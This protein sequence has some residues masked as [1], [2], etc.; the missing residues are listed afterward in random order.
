MTKTGA[1]TLSLTGSNTYSGGT[2][3]NGGIL[4]ANNDVDLGTG[5]LSFNGGTLEAL[6]TGSGI[7][8]SK[9]IAINAGGGTFLADTG[10]ASSLSGVISGAG[11]FTKTGGGTLGLLGTNT[12]AGGTTIAA[13][14]L[15][16]GNGGTSGSIVGNVIDNG[17]LAFNRSDPVTFPGI[18]S[19]TGSL[20][21]NGTGTLTLTGTSTY[22]GATAVSAGTLQVNGVLGTTAVT[23][24]SGAVLAGQGTIGGSVT[25]QDG[26]HLALGSTAQTLGVG[27]LLLNPASILD[28]RL[29]TP[30]VIGSGVNTL[31]NVTGNL[32][33]DGILNVTN[34]GNFASG[35]YRLINYSGA[36]TD[37]TLG[38]GT[39]PTGFS[40]SNVTVTTGVAGQVNLVVNGA[41]APTQFWDGSN[42]VFDHIVHGGTGTWDNFTTNFTDAGVTVNQSWQNGTAVFSATPGTVTLGDNI[43][44]Q[45]M[46]FT[47]AGYTVAGAGAFALQPTGTATIS[48]DS[49]VTATIGAPIVGP[50]GLNKVGLGVL[51]LTGVNT[52]SGGTTISQGILSVGGDTNLGNVSGGL[53]LNGGELLGGNGFSSARLVGINSNGGTLAVVAGGAASLSGNFTGPGNLTIGDTVNTGMVS[54]SG[55]NSYFGST[56]V[57][58]GATLQALSASALSN[59]SAFVVNGRL[60]LAGFSSQI[61]S[62]AGSGTVTSTVSAAIVLTAGGNN[63]STLFS[64]V[65][66]DGNGSLDLTKT[67]TGTLTLTGANSYNGGT[68]ISGGV[69]QIGSGPASGSIVGDVTDNGNLAFNRSDKII[70]PGIVSGAGSLSQLGTGTLALTAADN[71]TGGTT[72]SAGTLQIGNGGTIGSIVGNV[73]DNGNLA[74][75]R[76]DMIIF[77]GIVSGAGS[78][79]QVGTGTLTL[80]AADNYTGG[81]TISAGTLQIGNGGIVGSIVGN[82]TD[83]GILAF[84]HTDNITFPGI[85]SGTGTLSQIGTGTLTLTANNIYNGGTIVSGTGTL[86]VDKDAE[87][88]NPT[89]G[90]TLQGGELL[91]TGAGFTTARGVVV[92]TAGASEILAAATGTT[93]TYTGVVSGAGALVVGEGAHTGSIVLTGNNSY[94]GGTTINGVTLQIGNG[95]TSGSIAGSVA[96]N[97]NLAF[98][99]SDTVTFSGIVSGTGTLNQ[100]GLGT[101]ILTGSSTYTGP[102]AVAVGTLQVDGVLGNTAVTVQGGA[103][104]AGQ[105]T[106]GGSV[107]IQNGAHLAPGPGAQ[108]LNV[109][110]L[111]LNP[112]SILDY[113]LS[114][115]GVIG[116]GVNSLVNVGGNLT[117]DGVL[118]VTN[119][120]GFGSGAYR[121]IN[122]TGTLSDLTLGLGTLPA[123]FTS[124]NVTVT[125]GVVGQ[126]NLVVSAAGA[127]T[128][129]W[130]GSN[131]VSDGTVHGGAGIW[132]NFTTNFTNAA[133]TANQS[134]QNGVAVF[135]AAP[136]IV[137]LGDNILFQGMQFTAGGYTI[138]GAGAFALQ[139]TGTATITTDPGVTATIAAP[140]AGPG[141][142]NKAGL[143]VLTLSGANTYS[144]GTTISQG[145]LSVASDTNLGNAGV[146]L[147]LNGGELLG[148]NGFSSA[149]AVGVTGN[150]GTLSAVTGGAASFSGNAT[151]LGNLTIGDTVNTG[152][153]S[154]SGT[155]TYTGS[156]TIVSGA[157]L[158]ALSTGAFS[159]TSAFVVNGQLDLAGF[160]SQIGSLAG[161]GTVTNTGSVGTV[162]TAGVNNSSTIFNGVV[163]DGA[164]TLGL[165]K[166]GTGTLTLT[167]ADSYGGGTT[168]SA[169]T[170]QIGNAGTTGSIVGNVLDNGNLA[171]NRTDNVTFPGIV[172][173]TGSLNQLG[174]GTLTLTAADTYAGITTISA[175]TLQIG[176]GGPTGSIV[177][178]VTDNSNLVFSRNNALTYAGAVSGT[179]TL[180]QIGT[181]TLALTGTNTYTGVTTISA[182]TLQIGNGGT[183]GSIVGNV[184][185]NG[186][187]AY[188]RTDIVIF[189]GVVSGTGSLSQVGTGT[190]TLTGADTYAGGTTIS[191]GTLQIGNAGTS[192]SIVGNVTDNG[193]LAFNR[194]DI[195]VFPGV[196]SGTGS[197]SQAGTGTVTLTAADTYAGGTTISAGTLQIGNAGTSGSL[198]GNVL[199]N[200]NLAFNHTDN[201][202]FPGIVAGTGTLKQIGTGTLTLTAADTYTGSTTISA[203]ILQIG[204]GG[205][206][207]SIV[208]N[209]TDNSNLSFN[210]TDVVTYAGVVSG[211]GTLNQIGTGTL[212]L[213]GANIYTGVTTISAGT[214]QIGNGGTIGSIVGNVTDNSNLVFSRS[215]A[216]TYAGVV[217]GA[218]TLSQSGTGTLTLTGANSYTGG[219][220]ING[221]TLQ[222]GNAGII[223]SIVGDVTDNGDLAFKRTDSVIFPGI[224]SG[225]G[226]LS[227]IGAG[228]LTLTVTDTYSGGT[229]IS[230]GTLQIGNAGTTGSIVGNVTD[231]GNLAFNRTD[232]VTF[233]GIVSGTGTLKQIGTGTLTLTGANIYTGVTTISAGTLQIGNGATTGSIVGD[234]TDNS[235]LVFSRNNALTY[236]G[237]VSGAGTLS[238][239]GTGTL[240]LTGANIYTGVTTISA[241]TLQIGNGATT[242]SIVGDVTDN[243]NL[244]FSRNNALTYAG[245]VSGAGTLS[246][247]GTGTLTLTGANIYTG[248]TT[249]SAG[250]LQIGNGATT[251]SIVGDVTD[252]SNLVFSRNNALTYAGIVSGAGTLSQIGTG[253][254][255]LTGANIYTG[256]TT[257]SAGTLQIGNG[258]TTGSITGNVIDNG[259][260]TFSHTDSV[261]FPGIVSG[262]GTLSQVGTG[263]L[264]LTAAETYTGVTTIS[265]GTLQ[266]GNGGTTGS[267]V[268]NVIDNSNLIFNRTNVA[269]YAGVV[270]GAGTLSQ[271]GTGT[272]TLTGTN[273]Y[274]GGTTINAGTLLQ[275][276]NGGTIGSIVGNVID[277]G[278]LAFSRSDAATFSGNVSGTG[279]LSQ[280]GSGTLTL[281]GISTYTG[282]TAVSAGTLQVN[283]VLGTTAVTVQSGAVLAGG[284]TIGGN[285]TIQDGGHLAPG[286]TAQTLS[287]GPLLLNPA[288]I[289]DYRLST[290]GVIGRHHVGHQERQARQSGSLDLDLLQGL[291]SGIQIGLSF[292]THR[293][294]AAPSGPSSRTRPRTQPRRRP[295]RQRPCPAPAS[296]PGR[297]RSGTHAPARPGRPPWWCGAS[298]SLRP[299]ATGS[300]RPRP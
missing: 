183:T 282:A 139:P 5:V 131:T 38:L 262:T 188:N 133:A 94:L 268:G 228:T 142:L 203:G 99:R 273:T 259:N 255:T 242:G 25:I 256:V 2:N 281:T 274:A 37:L 80:T 138:A 114:T 291:N 46:Q 289:L 225:T 200:G 88:G 159:S 286:A 143:G 126:V 41:G 233:L 181:G 218:G 169:G 217:S 40:A 278:A 74:F 49:G 186:N 295:P 176:D 96:D 253:T 209:V 145:I 30:G 31:V 104:M 123:G 276:G 257:I 234:V 81:T 178:A 57:V 167:A 216:L 95:G 252:N 6:S 247:I 52:Y 28:Y 119:G 89:G 179:G 146:G 71:Y 27:S 154:L 35:A 229:T 108:T 258:G 116:S 60:D 12:Y 72:I 153:V 158:Q 100:N 264:T 20:N 192:G 241:G 267:I 39:L 254:L 107:A 237:V 128:Q 156:T 132:N 53:T 206:T 246:Q 42:T 75:N 207:G 296:R 43:L 214:L 129:F 177:G 112:T 248:V 245:I 287:V 18:V 293:R 103:A 221:G 117:L 201:V 213:T 240:T 68:T 70:F 137:T 185:D 111:L 249:I 212:T 197:L 65:S 1:G 8:S 277:N 193:N 134:W 231:N 224:V 152:M 83:N 239:I 59:P 298:S 198:V 182:G 189:P 58:S 121:L 14:T 187:F 202:I 120:G 44:F 140:I 238:Q 124:A 56:T 78:L 64:G 36:L 160:S 9:T 118:N 17:N 174:T 29:S 13:G 275:L 166:V 175:G 4:A 151:G 113:R 109:G 300:P 73:T 260:L 283:G 144:G 157:T 184:T 168:I 223:G 97:G 215:N 33:L 243:S 23:V 50:G 148:G 141:G 163:Q 55:I 135:S 285:V 208:G 299:D 54:L 190:V 290:P 269:T 79:S 280:V 236:A 196:V 93:A 251:G 106:I 127:P 162:L 77:P 91:T 270:S 222:V 173:G 272:L 170:L 66:Q 82:V 265:A 32:T 102:T 61:G 90:I 136:G 16:I 204:N 150:G 219:T 3:L 67:G 172:S 26:G 195:V 98:N 10:T 288:S 292:G 69:L 210:R 147:T 85:V 7:T 263:T 110:S 199:D 155:N 230:A 86:S 232:N 227:Q 62:L 125:T 220:T 34:G 279:N 15:Q 284:G 149:R 164:G 19:G 226:S 45:G 92:N 250:T 294:P 101:L 244:V 47:V 266:I 191:A 235:N 211:T 22:T 63:T 261:I 87:L 84:N 271:I 105:G 76:S 194:T 11:A 161:S 122:Y 48:T 51:N 165:T 297:T 205:T 115:P 180:T 21:Q 24:Q 171:F 130:D